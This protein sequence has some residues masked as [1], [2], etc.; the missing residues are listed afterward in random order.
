MPTTVQATQATLR[1]RTR[2]N[3]AT[4]DRDMLRRSFTYR[5]GNPILVDSGPLLDYDDP[6]SPV[7]VD[8]G[9]MTVHILDPAVRSDLTFSAPPPSTSV[10]VADAT[11]FEVGQ[12]VE[13][14]LND[15]SRHDC[16]IISSINVNDVFFTNAI[17]IPA[18]AG[19]R[20]IR[21]LR[22]PVTGA[23]YGTPSLA[24]SAWGY[25]AV[26]PL[27]QLSFASLRRLLFEAIVDSPS[28]PH[29]ERAWDVLV[30]DPYASG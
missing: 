17:P 13:L 5:R 9:V 7:A 6:S 10:T 20:L 2:A 11:A 4:I 16:G 14:T 18:S 12:N 30:A 1:D 28:G 29:W 19:R 15:G 8:D 27:L 3:R 25:R 21:R 23:L 24:S 26:V 22:N